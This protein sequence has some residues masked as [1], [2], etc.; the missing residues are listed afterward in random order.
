MGGNVIEEYRNTGIQEYRITD[1]YTLYRNSRNYLSNKI[2]PIDISWPQ[3]GHFDVYWAV[4][5]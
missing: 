2:Q 5:C 3:S 1:Y 4:F